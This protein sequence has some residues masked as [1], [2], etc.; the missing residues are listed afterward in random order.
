MKPCNTTG[1]STNA[2]Y[3]EHAFNL[4]VAREIG[5]IL[6]SSGIKVIYTREDDNSIG[7]CVDKRAAIGNS[8]NA[9]AV[10]SIHA[11]GSTSANAHGFH[12]AYSSPPLN[13]A[14]GEPSTKLSS[15]LRDSMESAGFALSNY[16]GRNG[17]SPRTDLAGLNLSTRPV[18]LVECG[19]MR[20]ASEAALMSTSDGRERYATAIASGIEHFLGR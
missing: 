5:K 7:P 13:A 10:I 3:T 11:D 12:V 8:A 19:N 14:Q 6:R 4:A 2:G 1:T 18:A 15:A 16:I 20:N 9:D 17:L